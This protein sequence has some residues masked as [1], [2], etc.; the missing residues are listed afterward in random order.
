MKFV[1]SF[2]LFMH[3]TLLCSQ[4]RA[5]FNYQKPGSTPGYVLFAPL[6]SGTTYLIDK[7]GKEVHRWQSKY[8]P[9]QSVYLLENGDLL[10]TGNDSNKVFHGGGVIERFDWNN[11]LLWSYKISSNFECQHHDICALPNG[12]ILALVW[13]L[14]TKE[15]AL[16]A[17]RKSDLVQNTLWSEFIVELQP[18]G[19]GQAKRVWEW[20]AWDHL[21]QDTDPQ[22]S[23]YGDIA[24]SRG[25]IHLNYSKTSE[26][27]FLHFNSI[28]YNAELDQILI[29]NRAYSEIFILDHSTTTAQA[30]SHS[31]GRYNKGGDLLYR[32]GNPAAYKESGERLLYGQHSPYWIE[33]GM[34]DEGKILLFN[35]GQGRKGENYSSVDLLSPP[36]DKDGHYGNP[37]STRYEQIYSEKATENLGGIFFSLNVSNAQRLRSGNTLVCSGATGQFCE[38]DPNKN[39][40]WLYVN[41]VTIKG[42]VAQHSFANLNQVFRCTFFEPSF[43]GFK[44]RQLKPGKP[45]EPGSGYDCMKSTP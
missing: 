40:V 7:C 22:Q 5:G 2:L 41:P 26:A 18:I 23:N 19:K 44:H 33:K 11:K 15:D 42:I 28:S 32:F 31:G 21:V 8:N 3:C 29:S 16:R 34:K 45:I 9:G 30:A 1:F 20:H 35:N 37:D 43:K 27:D 36:V 25:L 6:F 14:K 17:G 4:S 10:R 38:I 12:N 13:E 24:L 39:I